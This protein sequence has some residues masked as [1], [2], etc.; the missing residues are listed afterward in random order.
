MSTTA[1]DLTVFFLAVLRVGL[2]ALF[3]ITIG[4]WLDRR[5]TSGIDHAPGW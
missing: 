2:P 1:I 5:S 3:L 4:T